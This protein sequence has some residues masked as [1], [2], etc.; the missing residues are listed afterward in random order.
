MALRVV[1]G[2]RKGDGKQ[3]RKPKSE[4]TASSD[5]PTPL[6]STEPVAPR[7]TNNSLLPVRQQIKYV[8][9]VQA[10]AKKPP[11]KVAQTYRKKAVSSVEYRETKEERLKEI[12][13]L[14]K[15][16]A[17]NFALSA[18][19]NTSSK[20]TPPILLVD[21]Y[22]VL[23]KRE[24][25]KS[26]IESGD[27]WGAREL[28]LE[29]L[30]EYSSYRGIRVI[31]AVDAM[32]GPTVGTLQQVL[33]SNGVTVAYCGDREA[34]TY[35]EEQASVWL[36]KGHSQVI[37]A[38]DDQLVKTSVDAQ[39]RADGSRATVW[40]VPV[41]GLLNDIKR[42]KKSMLENLADVSLQTGLMSGILGAR[43]RRKNPEQYNSLQQLRS[44]IA[45]K[46]QSEYLNSIAKNNKNLL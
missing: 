15:K 2:T 18:L 36:Q 10:M 35:I 30:G 8:K 34:D 24:D 29:D 17:E 32:G 5:P 3:H 9:A 40:V 37:I 1:C 45:A 38:T 21:V 7:V 42:A 22:N 23:H 12:A 4:A 25:T 14:S 6:A 11:T 39:R 41:S 13:E 43:V 28:L 44:K 19:Y 26:F 33:M 20:S 31:A 16:E 27:L 46:Q